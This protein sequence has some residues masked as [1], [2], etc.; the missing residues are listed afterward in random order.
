[1][2]ITMA[3]LI[4]AELWFQERDE[5]GGSVGSSNQYLFWFGTCFDVMM[6]LMLA[7]CVYYLQR[8]IKTLS[9]ANPKSYLLVWHIVNLI[10]LAIALGCSD[11]YF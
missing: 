9:G 3:I 5:H 10:A 8:T 6:A 7:V 2:D 11:S 4:T 1:M